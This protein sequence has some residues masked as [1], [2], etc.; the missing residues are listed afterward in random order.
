MIAALLTTL[1]FTTS[2][3]FDL[4]QNL[5][6]SLCFIEST[7]NP[8]AVHKD[9]GT[10]NSVGVCQ[11]KLKTAKWLG[12]KGT[13]KQLMDPRTNIYY[14][15]KYL[16]YQIDRYNSVERGIVAYNKGNAKNLTHSKYSEKVMKQWRLYNGRQHFLIK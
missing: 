16:K 9:D 10:T 14:A 12:F 13:E 6:S 1:F 4:P 8:N 15:A 5:L 7:H 3:Q 11:L 2:K